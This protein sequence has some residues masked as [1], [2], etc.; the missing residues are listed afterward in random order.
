MIDAERTDPFSADE[1]R[2]A[3]GRRVRKHSG[4]YQLEGVVVAAFRKRSGAVRYVVEADNP[5]GLLMIYNE[6]QLVEG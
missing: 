1:P 6:A 2:F 3:V 4:D 5:E